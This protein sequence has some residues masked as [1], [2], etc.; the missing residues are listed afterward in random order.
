MSHLKSGVNAV[1][2]KNGMILAAREVIKE[3][4][5]NAKQ[6]SS[7]EEITQVATISA[8]DSMV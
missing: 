3:L 5:K 7:T 4:E 2:L 1:E 8:Q 6:I